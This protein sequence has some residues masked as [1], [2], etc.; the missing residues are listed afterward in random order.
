MV[1]RL[2]IV[3]DRASIRHVLRRLFKGET[4]L[5]PVPPATLIEMPSH[6][7]ED[8]L[9]KLCGKLI[10][11]SDAEFQPILKELRAA[12]HKH[13]ELLRK[14]AADQLLGRTNARRRSA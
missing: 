9:R 5:C 4:N 10:R 7:L 6:R 2:F 8:H 14:R 11:A 1:K 12:L 3:D 13:N